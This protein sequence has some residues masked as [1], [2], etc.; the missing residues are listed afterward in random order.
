MAAKRDDKADGKTEKSFEKAEK[1]S[2]T[3]KVSH[4]KSSDKLNPKKAQNED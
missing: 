4:K 2:P 1:E 3:I